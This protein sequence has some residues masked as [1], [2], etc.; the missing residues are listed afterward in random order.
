M[1]YYLIKT[2]TRSII[3]QSNRPLSGSYLEDIATSRGYSPISSDEITN[4]KYLALSF[5]RDFDVVD[6][7]EG[8]EDIN[9][10][11]NLNEG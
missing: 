10:D 5:T 8:E 9:N 3:V 4:H 7:L 2:A 6:L 11:I 1:K